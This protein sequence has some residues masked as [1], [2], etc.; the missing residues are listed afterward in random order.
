MIPSNMLIVGG[1][2]GF[3]ILTIV[4]LW[5]LYFFRLPGLVKTISK[6]GTQLRPSETEGLSPQ[7]LAEL[8]SISDLHAQGHLTDQEFEQAKDKLLN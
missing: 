8:Q 6:P 4:I 7:F 3:A 5:G 1:I 2:A